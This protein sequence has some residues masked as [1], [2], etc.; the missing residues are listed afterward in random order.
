MIG[1]SESC[2]CGHIVIR[3]LPFCNFVRFLQFVYIIMMKLLP[4]ILR[5]RIQGIPGR[6][7]LRG[8]ESRQDQVRNLFEH[9]RTTQ[10]G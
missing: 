9:G 4:I 2:H 5:M 1:V 6:L 10:V 7:S 3:I 8:L